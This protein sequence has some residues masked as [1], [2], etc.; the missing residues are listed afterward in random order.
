MAAWIHNHLP[1]SR[2][3]F[4]PRLCAFNIGWHE[5]PLRTIQSFIKPEVALELDVGSPPLPALARFYEG[6][7]A[8]SS[9]PR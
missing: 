2:L 7:P 9:G 8:A 4:F 3:Q 5:K 6:F 1:Y